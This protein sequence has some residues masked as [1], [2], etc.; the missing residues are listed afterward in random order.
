[1]QKE[2]K[3]Q[4]PKSGKL[5]IMQVSDPQDLH[6]VR[7]VMLKMLNKAYDMEKPDLVVFTGDNILG[8]HLDDPII[9]PIMNTDTRV[10]AKRMEKALNY[11]LDPLDERKIPYC[12]LY[13]NHDDMNIFSKQEQAEYY[14]KHEYF[15]GLNSDDNG[16]DCD[17]YNVPIYDS[18]GEKV[19]YNLWMIDSAG[20]DENGNSSYSGVK[21]EVIE[22]YKAKSD[23][24]KA[25][26]GG[27]P[28]DSLM[29]QHIPVMEFEELFIPCDKDDPDA[30]NHKGEYLKL[31]TTRAPG[32][33]KEFSCVCELETGELEAVKNQG[34]VRAMVFGH[35]HQN[36]FDTV[37]D[38]VRLIQSPGASFRCEGFKTSRAIR[39]FEIDE[40]DTKN[41][42]TY[43]LNLYD[44]LGDN[45]LTDAMYLMSAD[46]TEKIRNA[47]WIGSAVAGT[48]LSVAG[49]R[50]LAKLIKKK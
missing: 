18:K 7:H 22:W 5:K 46:E 17:N 39:I 29:F 8:N 35:D 28:L 14:L 1:M 40:N 4:F 44:I 15:F 6:N 23:E 24:L 48:A 43:V 21:P 25:A 16:L 45:I 41:F 37:I 19:V 49:I 10:T 30:I 26:N 27:E 12:M 32:Y 47:I 38:G 2:M 33:A 42:N 13:G 3:I 9:G 31:D 34:D 11:I 50:K 20:S 36:C